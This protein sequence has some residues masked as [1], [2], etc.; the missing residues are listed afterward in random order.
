LPDFRGPWSAIACSEIEQI[1]IRIVGHTVP[2][3]AASG[4]FVPLT[5]PGVGGLF[6]RF[7]FETLLGIAGNGIEAP[8]LLAGFRVV[9]SDVSAY[10]IFAS[11]ITN[12]YFSFCNARS[13]RDR[14][15]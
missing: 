8:H 9:C 15:R 11:R 1:G 7:I 12:E 4:E 10:R 6:H 5:A 13:H 14:V 3:R 2:H